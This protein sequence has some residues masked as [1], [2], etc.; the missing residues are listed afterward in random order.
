MKKNMGSTD[1]IIRTLLAIAMAS[2]A[3]TGLVTG[4]LGI[5]LLAVA[6]IFLLTSIVG[7]C[8]IYTLIGFNTCPRK[9][10]V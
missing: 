6:G 5:I 3:L 2:L 4:T 9:K 8:P 7:M 1:R 10:T